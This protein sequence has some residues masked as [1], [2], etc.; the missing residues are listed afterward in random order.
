MKWMRNAEKARE[1]IGG[2]SETSGIDGMGRGIDFDETDRETVER[3]GMGIKNGGRRDNGG[4]M[5]IA[6]GIKSGDD[7]NGV[8]AG[9][10]IGTKSEKRATRR[11]ESGKSR[12]LL[13]M[14]RSAY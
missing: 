12:S 4:T 9:R 13:G 8:E 2:A 11:T 3:V 5:K 10:G 1:V 14:I 6:R 7:V